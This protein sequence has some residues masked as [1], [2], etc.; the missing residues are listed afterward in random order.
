ML[1]KTRQEGEIYDTTKEPHYIDPLAN[2]FTC[3]RDL[4]YLKELGINLVRVYQI[5]PNANHDVCM[6]AFAEAGFMYWRIYP[7]QQYQ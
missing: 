6:N 1:I 3:L 4:D 7:N 2:P 5:H